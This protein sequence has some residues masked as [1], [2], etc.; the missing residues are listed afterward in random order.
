MKKILIVL[1]IAMAGVS[2]L[3]AYQVKVDYWI[4]QARGGVGYPILESGNYLNLGFSGG[5]SARKGFDVE[6]SGGGG[7]SYVNMPYKVAGAPG[8]FTATILQ[9]EGVYAPYLPDFI[10]WPYLRAGLGMWMVKFANLSSAET[11]QL[12]DQTT[13]GF[14]FGL[15]ASYP[16]NNQFA[17]TAEAMFNQASINGGTGNIYN[18]LTFCAGVSMYLK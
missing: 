4:V 14:M 18:F 12:S 9:L 7:I 8:P 6:L 3:S 5:V 13:F 16:I 2:T 10:I 1:L 17:V 11:S 15:G